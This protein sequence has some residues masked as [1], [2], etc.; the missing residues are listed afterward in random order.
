MATDLCESVFNQILRK[1]TI[2][3]EVLTPVKVS[4]L[5]LKLWNF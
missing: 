2:E 5:P 3:N 1:K 4:E